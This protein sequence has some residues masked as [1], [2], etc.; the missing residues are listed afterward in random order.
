MLYKNKDSKLYGQ[1]HWYSNKKIVRFSN[2]W[3]DSSV[4]RK[5]DRQ[6]NSQTTK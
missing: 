3:V 2:R 1:T 4:D 5:I 6:I